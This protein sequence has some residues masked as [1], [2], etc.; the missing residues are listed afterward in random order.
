MAEA[1]PWAV[2]GQEDS[3]AGLEQEEEEEEDLSVEKWGKDLI[4]DDEDRKWLDSLTS[5]DRETQLAERFTKRKDREERRK[6][7][8]RLKR[9][10]GRKSSTSGKSSNGSTKEDRRKAAKRE[11]EDKYE[12]DE[13]GDDDY[14]DGPK[15]TR[16][17][18]TGE[19]PSRRRMSAATGVGNDD[20]DDESPKEVRLEDIMTEEQ[21][22][23]IRLQRS[24][25]LKWQNEPF[26]DATVL[27]CLV[28]VNLGQDNNQAAAY[29]V[30]RIDEVKRRDKAYTVE[31]GKESRVH[32]VLAVGASLKT[33]R[34][35]AVSNQ[36]FTQPEFVRWLN[37]HK[38]NK[39]LQL[40]SCF[41]TERKAADIERARNFVYTE[42][43]VAALVRERSANLNKLPLNVLHLKKT[44]VKARRRV[45][46]EK[47]DVEGLELVQTEMDALQEEITARVEL[48]EGAT[49]AT[50]K[51]GSTYNERVREAMFKTDGDSYYKEKE[52]LQLKDSNDRP[53]ANPFVRRKTVQ[54]VMHV[55]EEADRIKAEEE[56][57][58]KKR[59]LEEEKRLEDKR[60]REERIAQSTLLSDMHGLKRKKMGEHDEESVIHGLTGHN[61]E[62][63]AAHNFELDI[64]I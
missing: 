11:L 7:Q 29:R 45:A 60:L 15:K 51:V 27:G 63:Q 17:V 5:L 19:G 36:P 18:D 38:Q 48:Q 58:R 28:R 22:S 64:D 9:Q 56:A 33:F 59:E 26:F 30:A 20:V 46:R 44:E 52:R 37:A 4:G 23:K 13:D 2:E 32:L 35:S 3:D 14:Y 10:S 61:S 39:E 40:P 8:A 62:M 43:G 50:A 34:L 57:K 12:A 1:I 41:D 47:G 24:T 53:V 55:G 21:A 16:G 31:A 42:E 49:T 25:L 54:H 6:A